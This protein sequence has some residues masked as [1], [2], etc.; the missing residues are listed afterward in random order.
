MIGEKFGMLLI[1]KDSGN[2]TNDRGRIWTCICDCG[3]IK[4]IP[5]KLLKNTNKPRSCGCSRQ[6]WSRNIF[7][8]NIEKTETCWIWKGNVNRGGYGKI[9]TKS[10]AHRRAYEYAYGKIPNKLHVCHQCDNRL[11]VNPSHL[12][13][14]TIGDNMQDM[15]NKGRRA[16]GSK[17]GTSRLNEDQVL[18]IRKLRL[19]GW[20][21]YDLCEKFDIG[22]TN[23]KYICKNL[24]WKHVPLGKECAK[25]V[26]PHDSNQKQHSQCII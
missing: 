3:N 17:T 8:S 26:S 7:E 19:S 9:G 14:G 1:I 12:F 2:R 16:R 25:Y 24:S 18:E 5:W 20:K 22:D 15:T 4:D 23:I 13:L 21:I 10:L 6:L 11:C